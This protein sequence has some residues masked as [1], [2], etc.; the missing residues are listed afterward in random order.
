[1]IYIYLKFIYSKNFSLTPASVHVSRYFELLLGGGDAGVD[2]G[3]VVGVARVDQQTISR[4][5][6]LQRPDAHHPGGVRV[7]GEVSV[8]GLLLILLPLYPLDDL[9]PVYHI[10][11]EE[12]EGE[13]PEHDGHQQV[14]AGGPGLSLYTDTGS[15]GGCGGRRSKD[16]CVIGIQEMSVMMVTGI[17]DVDNQLGAEVCHM[18][19]YLSLVSRTTLNKHGDN[20]LCLH[21][22]WCQ[23]NVSSPMRDADCCFDNTSPLS[24]LRSPSSQHT[25]RVIV[26]TADAG[27]GN[28]GTQGAVR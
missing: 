2:D 15:C 13:R 26:P 25:G 23:G 4:P 28:T 11:H 7:L 16:H 18:I 12:H 21:S 14:E 6:I 5:L 3:Q 1:M 10:G 17:T 20:C 8:H 27:T 9:V 22:S 24:L 19:H